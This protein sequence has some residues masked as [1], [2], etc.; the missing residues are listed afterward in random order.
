MTT[1]LRDSSAYTRG[2]AV[3]N[4]KKRPCSTVQHVSHCHVSRL[5]SLPMAIHFFPQPTF[6]SSMI[7]SFRAS[8]VKSLMRL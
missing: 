2:S 6:Q 1:L 3:A 5:L 4:K 8:W 7:P